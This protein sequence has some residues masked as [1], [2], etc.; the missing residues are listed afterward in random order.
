MS[1]VK[2]IWYIAALFIVAF[3]PFSYAYA[4]S[5]CSSGF[6][7]PAVNGTWSNAGSYN[8]EPYYTLDIYYLFN[9]TDNNSYAIATTFTTSG[10]TLWYQSGGGPNY[11]PT[12]PTMS[13]NGGGTVGTITLG[14]CST[15]PGP[16]PVAGLIKFETYQTVSFV[17]TA[18]LWLILMIA[19]IRWFVNYV[20]SV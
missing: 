15:P 17:L 13:N 12:S 1:T 2:K 20:T 16:A 11:D 19:F 3:G 7:I 14:A 18:A 5:Y 8:G 4:S 10:G 6:G 9:E